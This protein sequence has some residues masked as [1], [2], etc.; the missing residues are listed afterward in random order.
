MSGFTDDI[1]AEFTDEERWL[2]IFPRRVFITLCA[3][4]L[5]GLLITRILNALFGIFWQVLVPWLIITAVVTAL[6]MIPVSGNDVM[7]GGG[8][9]VMSLLI[10]KRH[11]KRDRKIYVKGLGKNK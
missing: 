8:Q 2:K 1:P 6:M 11:R 7:H 4:V 5:A 10:K 9:D 3:L